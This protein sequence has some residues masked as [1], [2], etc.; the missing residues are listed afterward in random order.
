MEAALRTAYFMLTGTELENIEFED[1]RGLEG[2]KK[3]T[4]DIDGLKLNVG[5]VNG[6]R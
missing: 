3:S 4:V 1:I 6:H 2:I 5:V